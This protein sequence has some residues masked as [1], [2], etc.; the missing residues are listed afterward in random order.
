MSIFAAKSVQIL[1]VKLR[2]SEPQVSD[3]RS[4][5]YA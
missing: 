2:F 5:A 3:Q 1:L 4:S